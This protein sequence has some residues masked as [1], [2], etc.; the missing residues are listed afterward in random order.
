MSIVTD[1]KNIF[2]YMQVACVPRIIHF[3]FRKNIVKEERGK[4]KEE[5][6]RRKERRKKAGG[7]KKGEGGSRNEEQGGTNE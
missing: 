2:I 1:Q 3:M 6:V 5:R 4:R 7:N